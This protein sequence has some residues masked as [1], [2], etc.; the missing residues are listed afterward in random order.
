MKEEIKNAIIESTTLGFEGHGILTCFLQLNYS[1]SG[2]GFGGYALGGEY[3]TTVIKGILNTVGVES[4]ENLKGKHVRV[5]RES[6]WNGK[7]LEIGHFMEDK[8]F[9]FEN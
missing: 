2:Q 5:K 1:G 8:W 4:W 3:T 7:I 9:S 6:D